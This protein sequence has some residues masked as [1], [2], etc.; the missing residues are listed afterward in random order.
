[1]C[2]TAGLKTAAHYTTCN[3]VN[4][5][6]PSQV[7][8]SPLRLQHVD[9]DIGRSTRRPIMLRLR[10]LCQPPYCSAYT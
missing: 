1:L 6:R 7:T 3:V 10:Q 8:L 9:R 5:L 2:E 4:V